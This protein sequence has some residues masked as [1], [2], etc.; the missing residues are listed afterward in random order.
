MSSTL[1]LRVRGPVSI[2]GRKPGE[3]FDAPT[4]ADG[5][6]LDLLTRKRFADGSFEAVTP[7]PP[8]APQPQATT[9]KTKKE[10]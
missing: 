9:A 2:H 7:E 1:R 6:L 8:P 4:D 3:E 5:V 10:G